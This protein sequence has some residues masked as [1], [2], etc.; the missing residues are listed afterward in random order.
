VK[1]DQMS[2]RAKTWGKGET[3]ILLPGTGQD[4]SWFEGIAPGM[5]AAGFQVIAVNPR[6][7]AGSTGTLE[8][9]TLHDYARDIALLIEKLGVS[10]AHLRAGPAAIEWPVVWL[11]TVQT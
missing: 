6:G 3:V 9:L 7:I 8:G 5:A 1:L 11:Q 2:L 4:T 10:R